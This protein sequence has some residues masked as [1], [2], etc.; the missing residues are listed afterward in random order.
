MTKMPETFKRQVKALGV[1]VG[2]IDMDGATAAFIHHEDT[3]KA[4]QKKIVKI[5]KDCGMKIDVADKG[6]IFS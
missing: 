6:A 4:Q 5:A 2:E 1:Y 3:T